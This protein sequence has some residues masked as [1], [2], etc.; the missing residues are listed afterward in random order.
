[1]RVNKSLAITPVQGE[2]EE[3]PQTGVLKGASKHWKVSRWLPTRVARVTLLFWTSIWTLTALLM[4]LPSSITKNFLNFILPET[5]S[6]EESVAEWEAE[7]PGELPPPPNEGIRVGLPNGTYY[8]RISGNTCW[9]NSAVKFMA[10]T[11]YFDSMFQERDSD[12]PAKVRKA[13][14]DLIICLRTA[15]KGVVKNSSYLD[16]LE[17]IKSTACRSSI[18]NSKQTCPMKLFRTLLDSLN[19]NPDKTP[20]VGCHYTVPDTE[21]SNHYPKKVGKVDISEYQQAFLRLEIPS[22]IRK[23]KDASVNLDQAF[24]F[25]QE[26]MVEP[27]KSGEV[28]SLSGGGYCFNEIRF[29]TSL[30]N[31]LFIHLERLALS[32]LQREK[33]SQAIDKWNSE[34]DFAPQEDAKGKGKEK[35]FQPRLRVKKAPHPRDFQEKFFND[36]EFDENGEISLTIYKPFLDDSGQV[37]EKKPVSRKFYRVMGSVIHQGRGGNSGH[38]IATETIEEGRL[39]HNDFKVKFIPESRQPESQAM[40]LR[41]VC[42][43]EEKII[44]DL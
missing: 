41:L 18:D 25:P 42:V 20:K 3:N 39:E 28:G 6:I 27:D 1:M 32:D 44:E 33:Y 13:L 22:E 14:R 36:I 37:I 10:A 4:R 5:V 9:F 17:A 8:P 12:P 16:V 11:S 2:R 38:Y 29:F 26:K 24:S 15:E 35:V 43:R 7:H 21:D 40:L 19:F 23:K 34:S 31:E 30:P